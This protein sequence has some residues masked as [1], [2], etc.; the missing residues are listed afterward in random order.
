MSKSSPSG[1]LAPNPG[2]A[3]AHAAVPFL[4]AA[5]MALA[6]VPCLVPLIVQV[7]FDTDP[8]TQ[9]LD[10]AA[11]TGMPPGGLGWWAAGTALLASVSLAVAAAAGARLRPLLLLLVAAGVVGVGWHLRKTVEDGRHG[12]AWLAALSLAAAWLH[13]GQHAAA[14]RW[15]GAVLLGVAPLWAIDALLY[16]WVGHPQDLAF[17][18]QHRDE[19]LAGR[20][21][22]PGSAA[23]VLFERRLSFSDATGPVGFS[24]VFASMAGAACVLGFASAVVWLRRACWPAAAGAALSAVAGATVVVL[25]HSKG[26]PAALLVTLAVALAVAGVVRLGGRAAL[27]LCAAAGPLAVLAV[28]AAVGVR[29]AAGEPAPPAGGFVPGTVVAGERSLLF[30]GHYAAAAARIAADHPVTG[31]GVRGFADRYPQVKPPLNPESV[32]SAHGLVADAVAMLGIGGWGVVLL[33]IGALSRAGLALASPARGPTP[34]D[35]AAVR[36]AGPILVAGVLLFGITLPMQVSLLTPEAA[37]GWL[38]GIGLFAALATV[39]ARPG[40]PAVPPVAWWALAVFVAVHGQ[41]EMTFFQPGSVALMASLVALPAG[42]PAVWPGGGSAPRRRRAAAVG[43]ATLAVALIVLPLVLAVQATRLARHDT[44]LSSAAAALRRG[45][46]ALAI[47]RL[48]AAQYAAGLDRSALTWRLRLLALERPGGPLP[49]PL[50]QA[51]AWLDG[52]QV[53]VA[54]PGGWFARQRATLMEAVASVPRANTD[55]AAVGLHAAAA[56]QAWAK[57]AALQPFHVRVALYHADAAARAHDDPDA[58]AALYARVLKLREENY[59]DAADPLTPA[60]LAR[61]RAGAS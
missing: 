29:L 27:A 28:L 6:L 19:L 44:L 31:S 20:G 41:V 13:L 35:G 40:A 7:A 16:A 30:R 9:M 33:M 22:E 12:A 4:G 8:R 25:T 26:A 5:L 55:P 17:F 56:R 46:R 43:K 57:A 38:V 2:A 50:A 3:W 52:A 54:I 39:V 14:R 36:A 59:L 60:Q 24:N 42:L 48:N 34:L 53:G 1:A 45:D 23:A 10:T 11:A 58:V 32:T 37:V 61:A 15:A 51:R 21:F 47:E 49:I 18:A